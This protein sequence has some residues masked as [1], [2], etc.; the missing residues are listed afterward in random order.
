MT[1]VTVRPLLS[2]K[3]I[4][5]LGSF[6]PLL[7]H[8]LF[9]RGIDTKEMAELFLNPDYGQ[10][11]LDPFLMK[12]MEKSVK[13]ILKAIQ[14]NERIAIFSDYDCDGIPAGVLFHDFF[15]KIGFK[16]FE[17]YIPHRHTEGF[18]LNHDAIKALRERDA[19]LLITADCGIADLEEVK[20]ATKLGFDVIVTDHH[21]PSGKKTQAYAVL[22]PKQKGCEYPNKHL[23]GS[24]VVFKLIQALLLRGN[25]SITEGW[26][27]WLLDL[28]GLAT[29]SDMVP[30]LGENR[31]LAYYGLKVLQKTRRVGL[32]KL[33]SLTRI[34]QQFLTE[35][36]IGFTV[37][38]RIN[39]ASRM[40]EPMDAFRLLATADENEADQY[41]RHLIA[42]NDER[43]GT[44]ALMVREM[45]HIVKER[46]ETKK[47]SVIV[48]GN[49]KWKPAL[50]GLVASKF[51]EEHNCPVFL[52]GRENDAE[53]KGSC[54]SDG[55]TN[56][57]ELMGETNNIFSQ[58][59]GHKMSGGF[60]LTLA[61]VENFEREIERAYE[62]VRTEE[63]EEI[64]FVDRSLFLHELTWDLY[65]DLE[66][67]APFGMSN[68]KPLFLFE[69]IVPKEVRN[70]GKERNHLE[71][72]LPDKDGF[73]HFAIG[74]FMKPEDFGDRL[75]AGEK[76]NLVATL[77]KST[78]KRFPELRLRIVDIF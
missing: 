62:K 73:L 14:K 54:R 30:L 23:C 38:P 5:E 77:E 40:G 65:R 67:L 75:H 48:M 11:V 2:E 17:N 37:A 27:K 13:R 10:D 47:P 51:V 3:K 36:D 57:L 60:T 66:K 76:I 71:L 7:A 50:L 12:D 15:I 29:L 26:E 45:K 8:L 22:D 74:F 44:V 42:L 72:V 78:F 6:S 41:A 25:F 16:N 68:P 35:D 9:H 31:A 18:G 55:K 19:T 33:F 70:F 28:V 52:W 1:R 58:F 59:G 24:G 56:M 32:Q 69:N 53:L 49:P 64:T 20:A 4:K 43:K 21:E 34:K 63:K 61:A 39:A 46:Y